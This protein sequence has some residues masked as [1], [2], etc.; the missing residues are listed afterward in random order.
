MNVNKKI[1]FPG[2]LQEAAAL[3]I[4]FC[5]SSLQLATLQ[6]QSDPR[7]IQVSIH[8][9]RKSI[10]NLRARLLDYQTKLSDTNIFILLGIY[11]TGNEL[12]M[13]SKSN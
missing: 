13:V 9:Y 2:A 11:S 1:L 8:Y 6:G 12:K 3:D 5:F 4:I 7:Q 10:A